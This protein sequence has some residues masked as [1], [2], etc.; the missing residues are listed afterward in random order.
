VFVLSST[1]PGG[2]SEALARRAAR[3]LPAAVEQ[4]W[5]HLSDHPLPP[6]ADTRHSTGDLP[7]EGDAKL[8]SD[9][10]AGGR[11]T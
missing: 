2:N 5:L 7:P 11:R 4:Q 9:Q 1:R 6:F 8:L 10:A 3:A